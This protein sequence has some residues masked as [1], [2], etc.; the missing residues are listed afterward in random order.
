MNDYN[1]S[2]GDEN[3]L[4]RILDDEINIMSTKN[5][6]NNNNDRK[7]TDNSNKLNLSISKDIN[8][9]KKELESIQNN[10]DRINLKISRSNYPID[11]SSPKT[12]EERIKTPKINQEKTQSK[13]P[14]RALINQEKASVGKIVKK[15]KPKSKT[16]KNIDQISIREQIFDLKD[17]NKELLNNLTIEIRT[18]QKL[19]KEM[20]NLI[21]NYQ[22]LL[23][24]YNVSTQIR[25]DQEKLIEDYLN[26][27]KLIKKEVKILPKKSKSKPKKLVKKVKKKKIGLNK[28]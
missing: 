1:I 6:Y 2:Y 20:E 25:Q 19:E 13:S 12:S 8:Y 9:L 26:E 7:Y 23:K 16:E 14:L 5:N 24:K 18:N 11:S 3:R 15:P 4:N 27:R 17:E 10:L 22:H 21:N 28:F